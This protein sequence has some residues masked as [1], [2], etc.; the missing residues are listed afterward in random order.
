MSILVQIYIFG[1]RYNLV[2]VVAL[3][4]LSPFNNREMLLYINEDSD[5][6]TMAQVPHASSAKL[7]EDARIDDALPRCRRGALR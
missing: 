6:S 4:D 3:K 7:R 1:Y 2:A 5:T